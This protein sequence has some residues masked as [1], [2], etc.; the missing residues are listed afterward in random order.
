MRLVSLTGLLRHPANLG[1]EADHLVFTAQ[2]G[3]LFRSS[4]F[5]RDVWTK[6][7]EVSE[8]PEGLLVHDLRE[9]A[10][11]LAILSGSIDQ[12]RSADARARFADMTLDTYGSLF[13]EDLEDLA[14]RFDARFGEADVAHARPSDDNFVHFPR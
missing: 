4:N 14:D 13:E 5:R 7:C 1:R 11:S 2:K 8:M 12:G 3:G 9:N 10:A 6:A